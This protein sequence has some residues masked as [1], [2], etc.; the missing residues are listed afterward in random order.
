MDSLYHIGDM[1]LMQWS[2]FMTLQIIQKQSLEPVNFLAMSVP[3][4][5]DV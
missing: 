5:H 3:P 2:S 1:Q 4:G